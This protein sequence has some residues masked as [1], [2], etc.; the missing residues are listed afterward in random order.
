MFFSLFPSFYFSPPV[1]CP[2]VT[3]EITMSELLCLW[4]HWQVLR[5]IRVW[6]ACLGKAGDSAGLGLT[7]TSPYSHVTPQNNT[8]MTSN[9]TQNT[10]SDCLRNVRLLQ[11]LTGLKI[12]TSA[13]LPSTLRTWSHMGRKV[14]TKPRPLLTGLT[15]CLAV[16]TNNLQFSL[17]P[18]LKYKNNKQKKNNNHEI[19]VLAIHL[20]HWPVLCR[21]E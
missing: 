14:K 9:N 11:V 17:W 3:R 15:T 2:P 16:P 5:D 7:L 12:W 10:D 21:C 18:S 20:Q 4:W 8:R 1:D 13:S 6:N 19:S